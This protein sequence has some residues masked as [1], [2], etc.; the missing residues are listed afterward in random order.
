MPFEPPIVGV[1]IVLLALALGLALRAHR[2]WHDAQTHLAA[3]HSL[4]SDAVLLVS[5]HLTIQWCN[6]QGGSLFGRPPEELVGLPIYTLLPDLHLHAQPLAAVRFPRADLLLATTDH[7]LTEAIAADG[8]TIPV[9]LS[10]RTIPTG[11]ACGY[12]IGLR[13]ETRRSYDAA[14]LQRYADQLLVTKETLERHNAHLEESIALR[15]AELVE[16]KEAAEAANDAKST[17]LANMSHE[18][19]TPLHGILSFSRFGKRRIDH[20]PSDKLR[21]YFE[22]IETCGTTLLHL[23]DQLLDLAK[24]E[25]GRMTFDLQ[26]WQFVD[27]AREVAGELAALAEE[28]QV[29]LRF[30]NLAPQAIAYADRTRIAQVWHNLLGNALRV[31]PPGGTVVV[32]ISST[33]QSLRGTVI[34]SGPGIP[35]DELEHIFG[36]FAQS[37]RTS[38]GAGGTGLGLSICRE[39]LTAHEGRIWAENLS[40]HGA[41]LTFELPL[42]PQVLSYDALAQPRRRETVATY[43]ESRQL[44]CSTSLAPL[45]G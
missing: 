36:T 4:T 32:Q 41:A 42:P 16:A 22:T 28:R 3:L 27:I 17:F 29:T 8:Y 30:E 24:M 20:V 14:S 6:R 19:R 40:P 37:S 34:D 15:T 21:Y 13:D 12:V 39:I 45:G 33:D 18:L 23:V 9:S 38:T 26:T 43:D 31:S 10:I 2:R 1:L 11:S 35:D 25:S 7:R 44:A 5:P